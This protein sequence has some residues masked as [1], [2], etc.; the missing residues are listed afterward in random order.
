MK[1]IRIFCCVFM[2]AVLSSC[3]A[4]ETPYVLLVSFDGFRSDYVEKYD[5]RHFKAFIKEGAAAEALI[6]C[7][8]S[9]TFANH[10]SIVTGLYPEHHGLVS[11][12]FLDP[13]RGVSYSMNDPKMV[14]D[15]AFYGGIPLWQ[16]VQDHGMRSASYYWV[17]SEAPIQGRLPD[18]WYPYNDST[19]NDIRIQTVLNWLRLPEKERPHFISLYFSFTD[20]VGHEFGPNS[21]EMRSAVLEADRLVGLIDDGVRQLNLPVDVILVSD[22]GM[23]EMSNRPEVTVY[24]DELIPH[25]DSAI[26]ISTSSGVTQLYFQDSS[27][28][29]ETYR[30]LRPHDRPFVVYKRSE[31]PMSWFYRDNDRIGDL[32][33][34]ANP[35]YAVLNRRPSKPMESSGH[36]WGTHGFDPNRCREM[37]GIFYAKGPNIRQG[38]T[39]PAFKNIHIYPFIAT[40]LDLKIP[41]IDGD[42]TV[43]YP[44]YVK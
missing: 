23:Y 10:Y 34:V 21:E 32:V 12:R 22:H 20:H 14:K 17:G 18:Y 9:L 42:P 39:I 2:A 29:E 31:T 44:I 41:P 19:G 7:F 16:L 15:A 40:I 6:P 38:T 8:P 43:L 24:L 26:V 11:N 27:R 37:Y 5:A 36:P 4:K 35:G 13:A 30:A 25:G 1:Q 33:L 28:L 3:A